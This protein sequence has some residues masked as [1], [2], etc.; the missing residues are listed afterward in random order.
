M[1]FVEVLLSLVRRQARFRL[2]RTQGFAQ[3]QALIRGWRP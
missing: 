1:H 2:Q 3:T